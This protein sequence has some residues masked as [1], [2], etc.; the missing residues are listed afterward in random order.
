MKNLVGNE[1]A[2]R[3]QLLQAC[4]ELL[5][6][7]T[8]Q[9]TRRLLHRLGYEVVAPAQQVCCGAL[10]Q[11]AGRPRTAEALASA[12]CTA[13]C[14]ND[15][16][17]ISFA[18]GCCAQ[19]LGYGASGPDGAALAGRVTDIV[20]LMDQQPDHVLRF[21]AFDEPVALHVPCT[22]R[23]LLGQDA[24][25]RVLGRIPDM[26]V[27][28]VNPAGGCCGAAG[29]YML[30]QAELAGRLGENTAQRVLATGA[31]TL[32]T[33]NIGC[34][35]HLAAAVRQRGEQLRVMHPVALLER[36]AY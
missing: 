31:R 2:I 16:P 22:Q 14:G 3:V 15:D 19:L 26:D 21:R 34:S 27:S 1:F 20:T 9:A 17:I 23:N 10:H 18:S 13:F 7:A 5:D 25:M 36:L 32:L 6:G 4:G 24:L 11:H 33:T 30:E 12:N 8:L 35:L 28:L 29:S